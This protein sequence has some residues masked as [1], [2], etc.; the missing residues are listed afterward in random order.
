MPK[1]GNYNERIGKQGE[2]TQANY[3]LWEGA[4]GAWHG[5]F[6]LKAEGEDA[7]QVA[8]RIACALRE[9]ART[10][11]D[12]ASRCECI[13]CTEWKLHNTKERLGE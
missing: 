7:I 13:L 10:R 6:T 5:T 1:L 11:P 12:H 3:E 2:Y 4:D 8:H 9:V